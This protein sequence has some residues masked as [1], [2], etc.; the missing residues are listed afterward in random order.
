M[1][2]PSLSKTIFVITLFVLSNKTKAQQQDSVKLP[3]AVAKEK[4]MPDDE[5]AQKKEGFYFHNLK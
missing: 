4:R 3:F 2:V 5:L 1:N